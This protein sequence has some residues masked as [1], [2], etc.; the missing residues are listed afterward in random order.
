MRSK[1]ELFCYEYIKTHYQDN[2]NKFWLMIDKGLPTY[3]IANSIG[4]NNILKGIL[5]LLAAN[6]VYRI[7]GYIDQSKYV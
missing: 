4:G 7:I 2:L 3:E 5:Y 1:I 6:N